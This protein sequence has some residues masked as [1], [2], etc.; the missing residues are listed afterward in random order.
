L[1]TKDER[2]FITRNTYDSVKG[3][4]IQTIVDVDHTL[5]STPSGWTTP[6]GGGL[7]LTTDYTVDDRGRVTMT[8]GPV[9]AIDLAGTSTNVRSI[10]TTLYKDDADEV[11]SAQGYATGTNYDSYTLYN[12]ISI[13]K[14]DQEGRA[15][16]QIQATRGSGVTTS[17]D[18]SPSDTF[19]QTAYVRWTK[20]L[21]HTNGNLVHTE[22]YHTIPSNGTGALSYNFMR[23]VFTHDSMGRQASVTTPG[24]TTTFTTYDTRGLPLTVSVGSPGQSAGREQRR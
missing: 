11:R 16:E 2:G 18:L 12:P 22:V 8:K 19:A 10:T 17:G 9:H 24:G 21:F 15:V 20:H 3:A 4:L 14:H 1:W 13:T 5:V 23:T 6:S 7:H